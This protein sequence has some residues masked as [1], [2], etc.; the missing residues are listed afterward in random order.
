M[1]IEDEIP[2]KFVKRKGF[3]KFC[4]ICIPQFQI[5]SQNIIARDITEV[6]LG[7]ENI[8]EFFIE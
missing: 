8:F 1:I 4:S 2:F 6:L 5:L 3:Q 7:V